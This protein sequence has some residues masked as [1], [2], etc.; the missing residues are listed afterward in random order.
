MLTKT[1]LV[2]AG[3]AALGLPLLAQTT[4]GDTL[5]RLLGEVHQLRLAMERAATMAPQVQLLTARLTVQNERLSHAVREHT[6]AQQQLDQVITATGEMTARLEA[7]EGTVAIEIPAEER[8]Q[9]VDL[10]RDLKQQIERQTAHEMRL[11]ARETELANAVSVERNQWLELNSRM[12]AMER[13]VTGPH[14]R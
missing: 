13:A 12:D 1:P 8:R 10:Q 6:S 11:R 4:P 14:P 5:T 9:I 7:L 2:L 3:I